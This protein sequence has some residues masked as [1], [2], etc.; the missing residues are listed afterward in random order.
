[1]R[2]AFYAPMKPPDHPV[3]SGDRNIARSLIAALE[4]GGIN[5]TLASR[6]RSRDGAGSDAAQQALIGQAEAEVARLTALGRD[7]G[8]RGWLTYHNYY[9]A[10]DLIGP[11]VAD[12]LAI[13]YLQVESTRAKKRLHGPWARFAQ[14]AEAATDRADVVFYF[15]RRDAETLHRDAPQQ[16]KLIHLRPFLNQ[17][18]LPKASLCDGPMLSVAMMRQGDK[19]ASYQIIAQTLA[20]L[21][22][23]SQWQLEIAGDGPARAEVEALMRPYGPRV[24]FLGTLAPDELE[25]C[26]HRAGLL[27]WPGVN[28]ALGMIYLE[29]Q[30][31]GL[32]VV[33]QDRP[34]MNEMLAPGNYP[35]VSAGAAG[36]QDA[37][38]QSLGDA[39]LRKA[40]GQAARE[41]VA[42]HHLMP[43]AAQTLRAGLA[44]AGVE[45]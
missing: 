44:Q 32:P 39:N 3:P 7:K 31:A 40:R 29:A 15:T 8:W 41:Y 17:G 30:G 23:Q 2:L 42:Q 43:S 28:E 6:L 21:P 18:S 36:L 16:Q 35:A 5:V 38:R 1:M 9:K 45:L 27:F 19:L 25:Q 22:P 37:L 20:L 13:P 14:R 26:Y 33:A 12:A 34:G 11:R 10:P 4:H 24:S